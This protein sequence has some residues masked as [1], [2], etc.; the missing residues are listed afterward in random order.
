MIGGLGN[1]SLRG[2][3]G[4]DTAVFNGLSS[5]YLMLYGPDGTLKIHENGGTST[6]GFND[7]HDFEFL[8][9]DDGVYSLAELGL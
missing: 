9:F 5:D 2:G 6:D 4:E 8:Q 3:D 1:D 7:L